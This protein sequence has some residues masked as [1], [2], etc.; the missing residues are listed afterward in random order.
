VGDWS[1]HNYDL[2]NSRYSPVDEIDTS[3]AGKLTLK[4]SFQVPAADASGSATPLV[5][6]GVMYVNAGSRLFALDVA[7]GRP[8]WT[9]EA[10]RGFPGGGR[11]PAY[12][13]GRIYAFGASTIYAVDAKT[14]KLVESFGDNG[15]LPIVNKALDFKYRGKYPAALDPTKL[16]YLMTNPPTYYNGTLY[17]GVP[18]SDSLIPGGLLIALDGTTGAIKWVFN[19]VPQGPGDEGWE[20]AKD[21]WS[22]SARYGGG[23]WTTPAIDPELGL[24]YFNVGNPTPNYDGSSRKG[25]N[26]FTN[27]F[28]ALSLRTGTLQWYYQTIHHDIWDWDLVSG[29]VLFDATVDGKTIRG[30]ASLGKHCQ[31]FFLNRETGRPI[32]PIVETAMPTQTD[33][34]GEQVWPT[35]PIPHTSSGLPQLPFCSTYPIVSDPELAKR[36]RQ[37]FYPYQA[38]EFVITAPGNI[39]GANRGSPSFSP[40]TG[41]LYVTGKNDAWSIKVKPVAD[42]LKPGPGN[43]GHFGLIQDRGETGVTPVATLAAYDPATGRQAWYTEIPGSTNSGN[44]VTGGDLVF[45]GIGNGDFYGFDARTG[46]QLFKFTATNGIRADPLTYQANGKQYVSVVATHTIYTFGLP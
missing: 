17:V 6:D 26:L 23:V 35:Q 1:L 37:S 2:R 46:R 42:T 31:A 30:I 45:Q 32:N 14:G 16:G 5:I 9:F 19:T 28:V 38:N 24:I 39:G 29:P 18:F 27:S 11:G 43:M 8:V 40:R 36:V 10:A 33:V 12:G 13:E 20:I 22:G 3:N 25:I 4:W 41:L 44:L 34:P 15:L 7:S 21:T